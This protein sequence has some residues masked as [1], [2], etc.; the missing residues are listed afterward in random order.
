[1][2]VR[3]QNYEFRR[4]RRVLFTFLVLSSYFIPSAQA[5]LV[6]GGCIG[7]ENKSTG[8]TTQGIE[9]SDGTLTKG[10]LVT[11]SARVGLAL[12]NYFEIGVKP[13]AS[14]SLYIYQTGTYSDDT[15]EWKMYSKFH[16]DW[17]M[18]SIAPYA[19]VGIL[20]WGDFSVNAE[21]TADLAWNSSDGDTAV[22]PDMESTRWSLLLTP[23]ASYRFGEHLSLDLYF[24]LLTVGYSGQTKNMRLIHTYQEDNTV[25][26]AEFGV[27]ASASRG[28]LLS[29][30][31]ARKL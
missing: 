25:D 22:A 15:K 19:R 12:G 14:L 10:S 16:K 24:N 29:L 31:I 4:C 11:V 21:V 8:Y 2:K 5:Q 13:N 6:V 27:S 1:M 9:G 3:T 18:H 26:P 28:T 7:Y 20:H 17:L 23:V 30:G